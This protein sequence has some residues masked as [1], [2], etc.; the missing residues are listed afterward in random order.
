MS[1]RLGAIEG[2]CEA[3]SGAVEVPCDQGDK[4]GGGISFEPHQSHPAKAEG[5]FE[6]TEHAL[7]PAANIANQLVAQGLAGRESTILPAPLL[8][9]E[10]Q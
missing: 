3:V 2:L 8:H 6:S 5:S 1:G 4:G 10:C 7:D 9:R